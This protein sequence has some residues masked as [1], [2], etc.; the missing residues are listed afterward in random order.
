MGCD[1]DRTA[2]RLISVAHRLSTA[3]S[4]VDELRREL[5]RPSLSR[6]AVYR[7]EVGTTQAPASAL[8]AAARLA[9]CSLD[10]L[11]ALASDPVRL[12]AVSGR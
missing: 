7:W 12:R 9:G 8:L 5:D 10:E 1:F 4:F 11:A 2:G 3:R 6:S